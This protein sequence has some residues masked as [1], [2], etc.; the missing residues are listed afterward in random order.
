MKVPEEGKELL[1]RLY[2]AGFDPHT[3]Q[4]LLG[5]ILSH[6]GATRRTGPF[7]IEKVPAGQPERSVPIW[8]PFRKQLPE[9]ARGSRFRKLW[10]PIYGVQW[11]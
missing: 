4:K 7:D 10:L 6:L 9:T 3:G 5:S 8:V 1:D 2:T 11:S